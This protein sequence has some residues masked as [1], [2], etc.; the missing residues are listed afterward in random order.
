LL[1]NRQCAF[2]GA[3]VLEACFIPLIRGRFFRDNERLNNANV[4][5]VT[6]AFVH[7]FFPNSDPI[8]KHI[9]DGNFDG[10]HVFEIVGVV[11]DTRENLAGEMQPTVYY[12]LYRGST[13]FSHLV[14]RGG[15]DVQDFALPVQMILAEMDP[16]L[17]IGNILTM[18]QI[19]GKASLDAGFDATL[20]V[21]FALLSLVLAGVG[22][23]GVL[24]YMVAQRTAEI[25]THCAWRTKRPSVAAGAGRW[26]ETGLRGACLRSCRQRSRGAAGSLD[27]V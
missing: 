26:P 25:G 24:S 23:F 12:P 6:P 15:G 2:P 7:K 8:G 18:N 19:L 17:A 4:A 20:L 13:G 22:I 21:S 1:L 10:P 14:I 9:N 16:Y 5:I 3:T 11:G 27:A